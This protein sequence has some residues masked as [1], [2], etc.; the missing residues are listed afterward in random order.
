MKL[1][2]QDEDEFEMLLGEIP[3]ATSIP[4]LHH[5]HHLHQHV[6]GHHGHG[7]GEHA[8]S[9]HGH[10][11][12][13]GQTILCMYDDDP[14]CHGHVCASSPLSGTSL[15]SEGSS[16]SSLSSG[17]SPD[18]DGSPPP[19]FEYQMPARKTHYPEGFSNL[20]ESELPGP[21][22]GKNVGGSLMGELSLSDKLRTMHIGEKKQESITFHPY[23]FQFDDQPS[24]GL[25]HGNVMGNGPFEDCKN[26]F[27]NDLGA[28]G[29]AGLPNSALL[30]EE[31]RLLML[32]LQHQYHMGNLSGPHASPHRSSGLFSYPGQFADSMDFLWKQ[33][34]DPSDETMSNMQF[35]A[36]AGMN[37]Y[38]RGI[39]M[40]HMVPSINRPSI[41]DG[42]FQSQQNGTDFSGDWGRLNL[43]SSPHVALPKLPS[44]IGNPPLYHTLPMFSDR[45][46]TSP[47]GWTPQSPSPMGG[48]HNFEAFTCEDSL[49]IQGKDFNFV[50]NGRRN[51][52]REHRRGPNND[53]G[54][55]H[56][57]ER[58]SEIDSRSHVVGVASVNPDKVCSPRMYCPS[59]L[60]PKY[61]SLMEVKGYIYY[62]AKDQH[63]CRFLQRKFDEGAPQ[64]VQMIFNEI[65]D[66][67]VELMM[68]PFGN[69]L[70]Q[71][72]LDVC[73][74][75]QK[76][77]ILLVVTGE[78][79]E[80]VRISLNTHGTRAVQ[81]LIET[82]KTREQTSL[83][84]SAL[85]PGFLDL[86]KDLN[87][88]HVVQRCLQ[89][90]S[91]EDNEFIFYAAAKYCVDIATH[92]HGCCVLQRCIAHS[93]GEHRENLVAE[94]SANG[95][96]LAQDAFGNY[97]IQYILELKLPS[98]TANLISQFEGNYV[99]LSTQKFSSNV[100]EKCLK[101]FG[102]ES[103]SR[104]IHELLST[105]R[106]E[107]LLQD[108]YANYVIQSALL[109]SKGPLH[110][111]LVEVI[112][113]H[114]AVL[115]TSPY[116]K[117][118]FSRSL[119]RK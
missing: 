49:I 111:S 53:T 87:G 116:C 50:I 82:L 2:K 94:I 96:L 93:T 22:I 18:D 91:N 98:A 21:L 29:C 90:L 52:L 4:P 34:K 59:L 106:F 44:G 1:E 84:I 67:V 78:P 60:P 13:S 45:S 74:E 25:N 3:H 109:V 99:H 76:M 97:V 41:T 27:S 32:G 75:E 7:H 20:A 118:I 86:I 61:N 95:L 71:K 23:G 64:D 12:S 107:Q 10:G 17:P 39:R 36:E 26:G 58:N 33:F 46:R 63:G 14:S 114:A 108:P 51:P 28:F 16:S 72:L 83:V 85:E 73:T 37:C 119:L 77:Q 15:S 31:R 79:G 9:R 115:R 54:R 89:C 69:Y 81:K 113:P 70:M 5:Q 68:N 103:R 92:R 104:I 43:L 66:H 11:H 88:N 48:G 57:S 19:P 105:S 55:G 47:N 65:I 56:S 6:H 38:H 35:R 117:R 80:L 40:P 42:F 24:V 112:R 101:F 100:V 102:E 8:H 30:D 62:I 110:A